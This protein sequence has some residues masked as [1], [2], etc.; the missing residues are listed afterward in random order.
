MN[1][2][3]VVPSMA[4][5]GN[6]SIH[7]NGVGTTLQQALQR[8]KDLEIQNTKLYQDNCQLAATVQMLNERHLFLSKPQVVQLQDF[9]YMQELLRITEANRLVITQ[10]QQELLG[11]IRN[12][13]VP[14]HLVVQMQQTRMEHTQL[15]KEYSLLLGRY[16]RLKSQFAMTTPTTVPIQPIHV[17]PPAPTARPNYARTSNLVAV[18]QR[19]ERQPSGDFSREISRSQRNDLVPSSQP[20]RD[21]PVPQQTQQVRG[22]RRLSDGPEQ[23]QLPLIHNFRATTYLPT[24]PPSASMPVAPPPPPLSFPPNM[25]PDSIPRHAVKPRVPIP[26]PSTATA[27]RTM[28]VTSS[29][30]QVRQPSTQDI[31]PVQG[32]LQF[33][34]STEEELT[35]IPA[36]SPGAGNLQI[37]SIASTSNCLKRPSSAVDT[38]AAPEVEPKRPRV[39]DPRQSSTDTNTSVVIQPAPPN[40]DFGPEMGDMIVQTR[41]P[42]SPATSKPVPEVDQNDVK[43]AIVHDEGLRSNEECVHLVFEQDAEIENGVFCDA[44]MSRYEAGMLPDPPTVLINPD[45]DFLVKHCMTVHPTLWEGLR[46]RNDVTQT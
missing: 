46:H 44:C 26:S 19:S 11:S 43:P 40:Q 30:P 24:P 7:P 15:L 36:V 35:P 12:E 20:Y 3:P 9:A 25:P 28:H 32:T 17:S 31:R 39:E 33:I 14:Q 13:T 22:D 27:Y 21:F 38:P 10:Q 4:T 45:F 8:I 1:N 29:L 42:E 5:S 41:V 34:G 18:P 2:H 16:T 37:P 23:S 6:L